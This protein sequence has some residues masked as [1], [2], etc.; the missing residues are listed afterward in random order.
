VH[1]VNNPIPILAPQMVGKRRT[2]A[3]IKTANE[4]LRA[5][6]VFRR[7]GLVDKGTGQRHS[8]GVFDAPFLL[9]HFSLPAAYPSQIVLREEG[10]SVSEFSKF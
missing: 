6:K 7:F 5:G 10:I 2:E 8:A 4:G 3:F 1:Q 9:L